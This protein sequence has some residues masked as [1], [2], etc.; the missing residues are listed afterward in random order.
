[1]FD[2]F[3]ISFL[4]Y[5]KPKFGKRSMTLALYYVNLFEVSFYSLLTCFFAA[6]ASQLNISKMSNEK[7]ITITIL[8]TLFIFG[9]N[10][11]RYNGKRRNVLNAKSKKKSMQP[12]KF[13]LLPM[14]CI[15]L[16]FIFY[17]AI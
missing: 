12:W 13:I 7:V 16:A 5:L 14:V 6:F 8:C 10:W 9:K 1:M 15:L 3:Y 2:A 4:N 11:M 17:K